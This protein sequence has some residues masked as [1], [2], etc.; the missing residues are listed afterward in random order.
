MAVNLA[1]KYEKQFEAAF[2]P[3][4]YFEGKVNGKYTFEGAKTI[5]IY[6]PVT[7][8]LVDYK[9]N[10]SNR[11]GE[12]TEMDTAVQEL[13]LAQEKGFTKSL[14][15]GNYSDQ[16]MSISAG[17]WMKEEIKGVI[18]PYTEKYAVA[19]WIRYAG[20]I[21]TISAVPTKSTIVGAI[22]DLVQAL[23]DKFVPEDGRFLYVPAFVKKLIALSD[24]WIKL[25]EMGTKAVG[26]GVVGEFM[27]AQVVVL[28]SSFFPDGAYALLARKESLLLPKKI[29]SFK[30][31]NNPPGI[32]GWLMEGRIYFDAFV[33]GAKADGVAAL[34]LESKKQGT[35]NLAA[36]GASVN[37]TADGA[38]EIRY[39]TDGT[40]PRFSDS[41]KVYTTD[42]VLE[43]SATVKAV[44]FGEFTSDVA[45]QKV[46][47]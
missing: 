19:K 15:R 5:K 37:I 36:S 2:K 45:E 20:T 11:Y 41:A 28:P 31:H 32:D 7:T 4:S 1:T 34:V 29:S 17:A 38:T 10:G 39:T 3:N 40:D 42:I 26:K 6:S 44:A 23:T 24:E 46:T 9:R 14:D 12:V 33:L 25:E 8:E 13:T 21:K 22:A 47:I 16:M 30:T 43:E 35:P 18:T 27:G